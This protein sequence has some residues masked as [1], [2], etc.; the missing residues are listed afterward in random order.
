M[1]GQQSQ[2]HPRYFSLPS[3]SP[4]IRTLKNMEQRT[5][6]MAERL[7]QSVKDGAEHFSQIYGILPLPAQADTMEELTTQVLEATFEYYNKQLLD[8]YKQQAFDKMQQYKENSHRYGGT[9]KWVS[10]ALNAKKIFSLA[11]VVHDNAK[12][13]RILP[14][15]RILREKWQRVFSTQRGLQLQD[16]RHRYLRPQPQRPLPPLTGRDLQNSAGLM[17]KN[18]AAGADMWHPSEL[19]ALPAQAFEILAAIYPC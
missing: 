2:D 18:A 10:R 9:N 11:G 4:K 6:I 17:K 14:A 8:I 1:N 19:A 5:G 7:W 3:S 16:W 15:L 12:E 13:T